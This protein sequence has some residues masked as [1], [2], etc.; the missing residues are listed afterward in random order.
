MI[1]KLFRWAVSTVAVALASATAGAQQAPV[2]W[3]VEDGGNGH[4]YAATSIAAD[5]W[6]V[7]AHCSSAGGYLASITSASELQWVAARFEPRRYFVGAYQDRDARDFAE[8]G[9]GWRWLSS[10]PFINDPS[11]CQFDNAGGAQDYAWFNPCCLG[12][13]DDCQDTVTWGLIEWSADCNGDGVVDFGQI[14]AGELDD[15]NGNGVP[16]LCEAGDACMPATAPDC[17]GNGEADVLQIERGELADFSSVG[18]PNCCE[19]DMQCIPGEYP[20][21]WKTARGG[22]G[23]WYVRSESKSIFE[24]ARVQAEQR[25]GHLAT[26][27]SREEWFFVA[28]INGGEATILGGFQPPDS[29]EPLCDWQWVTG[30]PWDFVGWSGSQPDDFAGEDILGLIG[31]SHWNDFPVRHY[32]RYWIEFDADCNGD[33]IVDF[34]Q[35][36][37]GALLDTNNNGIPDSCEVSACP[38]DV[39]GDRTVDGVD[40][41]AI[42]GAW[43]TNGQSQFDCDID[44]DGV[45]SGTDLAFVLSGWGPCSS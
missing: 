8:P 25:G 19:L 33:G 9:G 16:D 18:Q 2:Q 30:E 22:N 6:S 5:F 21:E 4:W 11:L 44:N 12:F 41:A 28:N 34:G 7:A 23:H 35:I 15:G 27:T 1:S 10:E 42:L 39:T 31:Q 43:G 40:L 38:A 37:R 24:I 36:L 45:V 20:V 29:C 26:L 17:D 32:G 14:R 3:R 13:L